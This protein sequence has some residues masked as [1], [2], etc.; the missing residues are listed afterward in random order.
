MLI[1]YIHSPHPHLGTWTD[2][3]QQQV[4]G[5]PLNWLEEQIVEGGFGFIT[6]NVQ[7]MRSARGQSYRP[8]RM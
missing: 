5:D 7:L 4:L 3:Q 2:L 6:H 8:I 1:L